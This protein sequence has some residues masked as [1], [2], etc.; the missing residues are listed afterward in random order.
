MRPLLCSVR[1]E[2]SATSMRLI[3]SGGVMVPGSGGVMVP[4]DASAGSSWTFAAALLPSLLG[5]LPFGFFFFFSCGGGSSTAGGEGGHEGGASLKGGPGWRPTALA[6]E[7]SHCGGG[8]SKPIIEGEPCCRWSRCSSSAVSRSSADRSSWLG[9]IW[10]PRTV[11]LLKNDRGYMTCTGTP[12]G[13]TKV[14]GRSKC[15]KCTS[16]VTPV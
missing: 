7:Q 8:S 16:R 11:F 5:L 14:L 10:W 1:G 6:A 3:A 4:L 13:R 15:S 2:F 12:S 9:A